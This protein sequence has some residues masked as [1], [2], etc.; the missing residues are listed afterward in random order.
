MRPIHYF[1]VSL[2]ALALIGI[3][4]S[5]FVLATGNGAPSGTHYNL[6][7][8]GVPKDKTADLKARLAPSS[9]GMASVP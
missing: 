1:L 7:I 6:N 5:R 9:S 3:P 4:A 8:I 2:L